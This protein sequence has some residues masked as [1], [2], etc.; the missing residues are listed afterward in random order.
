VGGHA[1]WV[2][3]LDLLA[4]ERISTGAPLTHRRPP[5]TPEPSCV[6]SAVG[7][8]GAF[9]W[10]LGGAGQGSYLPGTSN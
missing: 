4:N 3:P 5:T 7:G 1:Q 6:L 8:A 2:R 9:G 10:L